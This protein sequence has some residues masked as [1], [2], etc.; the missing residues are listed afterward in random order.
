MENERTPEAK[1]MKAYH[2]LIHGDVQGVGYRSWIVREAEKLHIVG[3][4]KNCEEDIV[5]AVVQGEE[6][7]VKQIVERCKKGPE[8]AWVENVEV[9]EKPI[10]KDL[11]VFEV[12]Y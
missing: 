3:W 12:I 8:V 11:F 9:T 4:V 1:Y 2:L 10:D 5:E 6:E 7:Q